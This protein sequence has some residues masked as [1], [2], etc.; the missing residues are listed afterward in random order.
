MTVLLDGLGSGFV[1][2]LALKN[3]LLCFF[4][5]LIGIGVGALPRVGPTAAV[6]LLLPV[7]YGLDPAGSLFMLA[8]IYYGA[9]Y[10][11][12]TTAI[13]ANEPGEAS[14]VVTAIDGHQMALKG[15]AG[16][17]LGIAATASLFAGM[18]L[19]LATAL[20]VAPLTGMAAALRPAD[21]VVL[22]AWGLV[23]AVVLSRDAVAR[24]LAMI[25]VGFLLALTGQDPQTFE[26]RLTF[27][28][29]GLQNGLE[30][31][32]VA[33]GLFVVA[34]VILTLEADG[35]AKR[36]VIV[37][38]RVLPN[39]MQL[40]RLLPAM[41]R[42][43][44]IGAGLGVLPGN[45]TVLAPFVS[46]RAE[47]RRSGGDSRF[48]QGA[49][50]GVAGPEAANNAGAQAGFIPFLI[51][52]LPTN[53]VMALLIG[54]V[55]VH[56]IEPGP[57]LIEKQPQIFWGLI[58]SM[59]IGNFLVMLLHLPFVGLWVRLVRVPFRL[60]FPA[61]IL[62]ACLGLYAIRSS[63]FEVL[64][65][66]AFGAAGYGLIKLGFSL[67]PL[68]FGFVLGGLLEGKLLF[69]LAES[70]AL[71]DTFIDRPMTATLLLLAA[72]VCLMASVPAVKKWRNELFSDR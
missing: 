14:S 41:G 68:V 65:A 8:G 67:L 49:E 55:L 16:A 26:D 66:A 5:C 3:A 52:G 6:T 50:E 44:A 24:S 58:A 9:Q 64:V 1:V 25:L 37:A 11:G 61:L 23:L 10:G 56:G 43:T 29:S 51:L 72:F 28:V 53:A 35:N 13:L 54:A 38:G 59:L 4:G 45:G 48:G 40:L 17:A 33:A 70:G 30:L 32:A 20:I 18:V 69:A 57:A 62:F 15:R 60:I 71:L 7:T 21:H 47:K 46:Y 27:G 22:I 39:G 12:A 19:T 36:K 42:G 31:A 34:A 2:A 63:A